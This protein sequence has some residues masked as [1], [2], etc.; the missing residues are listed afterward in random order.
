LKPQTYKHFLRFIIV[1]VF[2]LYFLSCASFSLTKPN[3]PY[4]GNANPDVLSELAQTNPLLVNE[5]GKLPELQ[6]GV[7]EKEMSALN[8]IVEL[9]RSDPANFENV[10][11]E[12]YKVGIPEIRRYCSPLQALFWLAE[13]GHVKALNNIVVDYSLEKLLD[14]VWTFETIV[15]KSKSEVL[16]I[17]AGINKEAE[18]ETYLDYLENYNLAEMQ[19]FLFLDYKRNP[20]MFS[21]KSR[22]MIKKAI[23]MSKIISRW[24]KFD[25]VVERLNSPELLDYYERNVISYKYQRG[26]G[27]G[28]G[29]ARRVFRNKYG[30]CAQISAFTVYILRKGGYEARRYIVADPVLRSPKGNFHRACLFMVKGKKYIMDNGRGRPKVE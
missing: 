19:L 5:L 26:Y 3:L 4:A 29:E 7:S 20:K 30:H 22:I 14:R 2:P 21:R 6:D 16:E 10:F 8:N 13:E 23:A 18:K 27:E 15:F 25:V 17:I 12:M 9:Y 24:D 1:L 28:P 11:N